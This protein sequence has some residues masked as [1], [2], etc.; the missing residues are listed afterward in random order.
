MR[1]KFPHGQKE[2]QVNFPKGNVAKIF[3]VKSSGSL[4]EKEI[5]KSLENP[6]GSRKLSEVARGRK[7]AVIVISDITRYIPYQTFLPFLLS[8]SSVSFLSF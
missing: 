7:D 2:I 6:A 3:E 5:K 8:L 4:T 1:I